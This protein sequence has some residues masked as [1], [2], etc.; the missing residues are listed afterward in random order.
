MS[1]R[2]FSTVDGAADVAHEAAA[3]AHDV[4]LVVSLALSNTA[5]T[6]TAESQAALWTVALYGVEQTKEARDAIE[7]A[8]NLF[9][10]RR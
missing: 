2:D 10:I 6:L 5:S 4:F 7:L 8:G 1:A 9:R 3:M